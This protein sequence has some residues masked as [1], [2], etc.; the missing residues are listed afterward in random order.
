MIKFREI[1]LLDPEEALRQMEII[2]ALQKEIEEL[3]ALD[4]YITDAVG[5]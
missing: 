5:D 1:E 4:E 3:D 2:M